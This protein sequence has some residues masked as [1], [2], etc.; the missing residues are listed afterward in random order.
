MLGMLD[1]IAD[2]MA[3]YMCT[4]KGVVIVWNQQI[5]VVM[6]PCRKLLQ[7]LTKI[8]PEFGIRLI[9]RKCIQKMEDVSFPDVC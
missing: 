3:D 8:D 9:L 7:Q 1:T 2:V 4:H 5:L 6:K